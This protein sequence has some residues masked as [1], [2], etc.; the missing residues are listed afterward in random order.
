MIVET[1]GNA[2]SVFHPLAP[3]DDQR[4][5]EAEPRIASPERKVNAEPRR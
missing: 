4:K 1:D 5:M 2:G 3:G